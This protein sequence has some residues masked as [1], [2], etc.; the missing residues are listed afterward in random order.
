MQASKFTDAQKAFIPKQGSEGMPVADSLASSSTLDASPASI[1]RS[2]APDGCGV[3]YSLGGALGRH[4]GTIPVAGANPCFLSLLS[5][6]RFA[7]PELGNLS[8]SVCNVRLK[9]YR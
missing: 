2:A 8:V 4:R 1:T 3:E 5:K 6:N 7:V 9:S